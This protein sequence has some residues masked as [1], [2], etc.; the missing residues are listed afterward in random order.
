MSLV[1]K[2]N[3]NNVYWKI[4]G[5]VTLALLMLFLDPDTIAFASTTAQVETKMK[6]GLLAVQTVLSGIVVAVGIVAS[7]K[8]ISKH[9]P[10]IDDPHVKNEMWKSLGNVLLGVGAAAA[11]VWVLPWAYNSFK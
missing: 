10:G 7:L 8:I 9:L 2:I 3:F 11:L 5:L 4:G 1:Y 6:K